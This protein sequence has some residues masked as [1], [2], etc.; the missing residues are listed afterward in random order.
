[1]WFF[2]E[3]LLGPVLESSFGEWGAELIGESVKLIVWFLP[4]VLLIRY[5]KND[6]EFSLREIFTVKTNSLPYLLILFGFLAIN[7][8]GKLISEGSITLSRPNPVSSIVGTV[9]LVGIT[10]EMVFRGF[11]QNALMKK[12][13]PTYALV[14]SSFMFL[15]IHFPIWIKNGLFTDIFTVLGHCV[16]I[17]ALS[18][19]FGWTFLKGKNIVIPILLH[20][21][22]NLILVLFE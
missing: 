22:W 4:S 5:Y 16:S 20:M 14:A 19:I 21:T 18:F 8:V 10:E 12:M 3:L 13:K 6:M 11:I 1:M 17:L 7:S 15:I 2:R 9:L